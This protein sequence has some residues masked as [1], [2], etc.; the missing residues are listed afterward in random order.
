MSAPLAATGRR[1]LPGGLSPLDVLFVVGA[2]ALLAVGH[3]APGVRTFAL[4]YTSIV[5][6]ALPFLLLGAL[7]GG[8]VEVFVSR[9]RLASIL[10][11]RRWLAV[12][13]AA[14]LGMILPVCE[15]AVVPVVRRMARK[16]LPVSAAVAYLLGGP[17]ANPIVAASTAVAYRLDWRVAALRVAGGYAIAVIAGALVGR[18]FRR[19]PALAEG[20]LAE[21]LAHGCPHAHHAADACSA[22]APASGAPPGGWGRLVAVVHHAADELLDVGRLFMM[23][24]FVAALAQAYLDRSLLLTV[25]DHPL[26]AILAMM[27]LA[28]ALNL[29]SEADAFVAASFQGLVPFSAQAAFLLL[30]PILDLKLLLMYQTLFRR[31]ATAFLAA[32]AFVLVLLAAGAVHLAG[33]WR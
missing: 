21:G 5:L 28:V 25:V 27:L 14:G 7:A 29:C 9:E 3:G 20:V 12:P 15:C 2:G 8:A 31:R 4:L 19:R 1:A 6:E 30:G 16:G 11:R 33:S 18:V 22:T 23:G 10:P 32:T 13:V 24:A 26:L 17:I